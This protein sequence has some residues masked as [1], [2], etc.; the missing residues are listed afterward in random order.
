MPLAS[1]HKDSDIEPEEQALTA[2]PDVVSRT[3]TF[4][5]EFIIMGCDGV[6]ETMTSA[7]VVA[8]VK[9]RLDERRRIDGDGKISE[10]AAALEDEVM[11]PDIFT[12]DGLGLDNMS[13]L[14][15]SLIRL[16]INIGHFIHSSER[17]VM[18]R[19]HIYIYIYLFIC[20]SIYML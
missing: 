10:V 8:F 20:I 7:E 1:R 4:E 2:C 17:D 6:W 12:S 9:T 13:D 18:M 11:A 14:I 5:D 16:F 19:A 15:K 3:I